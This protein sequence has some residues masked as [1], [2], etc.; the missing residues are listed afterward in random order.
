MLE[1]INKHFFPELERVN[2]V[3]IYLNGEINKESC[4]GAI[5][6]II[7][8][9]LGLDDSGMEEDESNSLEEMFIEQDRP[10]VIN[11]MITSGGGDMNSALALMDVIEASTIPVRTIAMGECASAA[12][13]LLMCGHQRVVT[14]R[15]SILSHQFSSG[16]DGNYANIEV[17]FQEF[18]SYM[19][20]ME[21]IYI[22]YTGLPRTIVK[23]KLLNSLDVYLTPQEALKY[24]I[25]DLVERLN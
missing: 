17:T 12:L 2:Q 19:K 14:P 3:F 6:Q 22:E 11:L 23:K 9:N 10:D 24:N 15:T 18:K 13:C 4:G 21:D 7:E 25:V 16:L 5:A 8:E 20:K 1:K